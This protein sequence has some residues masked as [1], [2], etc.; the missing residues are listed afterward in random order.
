MKHH[1][2]PTPVAVV[3]ARMQ[4]LPRRHRIAHLRALIGQPALDRMRRAQLAAL[5]RA[6]MASEN[7]GDWEKGD[8]VG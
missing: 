7:E 4:P 5:L 8:R 2:G 3:A 6:E 1:H